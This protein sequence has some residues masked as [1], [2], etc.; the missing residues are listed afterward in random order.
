MKKSVKH[1]IPSELKGV[2]LE[3]LIK[4]YVR[5]YKDIA[6]DWDAFADSQIEGRRRAQFRFIGAGGSGKEDPLAIPSSDFTLSIMRV[7]PGQG[8][9]AHTHEVA[10]AFI[11]LEGELTVFFEDL[12]G[13]RVS[14][15]LGQY[16]AISCPPGIPHGFHNDGN[17]DVL[18]QT[19][20]GAGKPGP[21]GYI[22]EGVY[23]EETKR[24]AE[25][26]GQTALAK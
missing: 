1:E 12:S 14:A 6:P 22:D 19:I 17:V 23:A 11:C 3:S 9:S 25:R 24:L 7:P 16:D 13:K 21:V 18:M 26:K 5:H 20:V 15:K 8:G 10:E 4:R 2:P